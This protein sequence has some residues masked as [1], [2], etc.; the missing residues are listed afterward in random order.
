MPTKLRWYLETEEVR[1]V[2]Q[3]NQWISLLYSNLQGEIMGDYNPEAFTAASTL[4][5]EHWD[6]F[7][8]NLGYWSS[9]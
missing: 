7:I 2:A 3:C 6:S 1:Q 9:A 5:R 4:L 8:A